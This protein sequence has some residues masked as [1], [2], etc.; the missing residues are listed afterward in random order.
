[1]GVTQ[2]RT[3]PEATPPE[4]DNRVE[5]PDAGAAPPDPRTRVA[6]PDTAREADTRVDAPDPDTRV[7]PPGPPP[8]AA[9]AAVRARQREAFGGLNWGAA[10]F[11]WLVAIGLAALLTGIVSATGAAIGLTSGDLDTSDTIGV[12]GGVLLLIVTLV[13]WYCG[14]YVAGRMSRF[15]GARQGFG[16][17]ALSI[18]GAVLIALAG[19]VLGAKYNVL[20]NLNLPRIP[21]NAGDLTT[22]G[23]IALAVIVAAALLASIAGGRIGQRYHKRID[24]VGFREEAV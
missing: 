17:W 15:D 19:W 3:S 4:P 11:G 20:D 24:Q 9:P 21:D 18:F 8:G 16:V 23:I 12:I 7:A 10:F 1:M 5:G 14:G 6:G 13:S 2:G 22:G